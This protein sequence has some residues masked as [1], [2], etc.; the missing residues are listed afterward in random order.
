M[1]YRIAAIALILS[2]GF[3]TLTGCGGSSKNTSK[4]D[5]QSKNVKVITAKKSNITIENEFA[6][7]IKP[8]D[9][10]GVI[11]KTPGKVKEV[12]VKV[13][14]FVKEGDLLFTLDSDDVK[15]QL[16]QAQS[17]LAVTKTSLDKTLL[18]LQ[19][20]YDQAKLNL[21]DETSSFSRNKVLFDNGGL[22]KKEMDS[23]NTRL[24]LA[25]QRFDSAEKNI[26]LFR[27]DGG[28]KSTSI[29]QS[30]LE[31]SAA[32]VELINSQLSNLNVRAPISGVVSI[33]NINVGEGVSSAAPAIVISNTAELNAEMNI[34]EGLI[35]KFIKG[36]KLTITVQSLD[37]KT[38]D[39]EVSII[40]PSMDTATRSYKV[41]I[42][43]MGKSEEVKPG[44]FAK[45]KLVV[46]RKDDVVTIPSQAV[47]T[48]NR[49]QYVYMVKDN[50]VVKT[51]IKIGLSNDTV[52]EVTQGLNENDNLIIEGQSFLSDGEK[53]NVLKRS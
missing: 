39:G 35:N 18:Q 23:S 51:S 53:I 36:Q 40:Y 49:V 42:K 19:A 3:T 27:N 8:S 21:D 38:F 28:M 52:V 47:F 22:S 37:D 10:A 41:K 34:P 17:G 11:S 46:E 31:Q 6:G 9:E 30:Q 12:L 26:R 44:M 43:L 1:K 2:V 29:A 32:S 48:E 50:K 33:K 45:I 7:E 4:E 5:V 16:S 24:D 15:A 14:D 13:G 25:K 20:E